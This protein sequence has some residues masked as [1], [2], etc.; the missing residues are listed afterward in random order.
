M[1]VLAQITS[2]QSG[3]LQNKLR[4][5]LP[6]IAVSAL[7]AITAQFLAEHYATPAMLLALLLGIAVSFLGEEGKTVPGIAFSARSLLRLG[8]ALL[9][10]RVSMVLM[11]GLGWDL[12][13]L[14]VGGVIA[15]I[16]FGLTVARFFGHKWRFAFLTAGSVAICGASAAM[17]ISAILPRDERSEERLIFTVMGVTVLSTV[18]MIAY[19]IL[20]NL[21]ELN[22]IQAGVFLGGTIHDVAQVVGA[23]FSISEQTGDTA[24][25]VKLMRVAMLAPIVLAAS[26][27]IRSFAELPSDGKRP[28]ILPGFVIAFLVLAGVNSFGLIPPAVTEF[29]SHASRWLLLT[30]IAAVG[31]KTNLKQVL[32]VGGAAIALIIVETLF[33]AGLILAGIELLT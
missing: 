22:S 7:V 12:I 13:A 21:L 33:I 8:V 4:Q 25:L 5:L 11:M 24:T 6:G 15:T 29:L 23:G 10:V 9:G 31:M 19:P 32:A 2:L 17:A 28:P 1:S 16:A 27:M 26:L 30:A 18:A 3:E 14:V 20:V